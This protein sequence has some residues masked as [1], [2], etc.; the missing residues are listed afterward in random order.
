MTRD[1][2]IELMGWHLSA[3]TTN[4]DGLLARVTK[5]AYFAAAKE[6]LACIAD[7][8]R[9]RLSL[10]GTHG[11]S[12]ETSYIADRVLDNAIRKIEERAK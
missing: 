4:T 9:S 2:I 5:V 7:V 11:V 1:E 10:D 12:H 8:R 3:K 6:R